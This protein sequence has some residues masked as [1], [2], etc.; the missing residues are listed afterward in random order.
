MRQSCHSTRARLYPVSHARRPSRTLQPSELKA[1]WVTTSMRM[2]AIT[3]APLSSTWKCSRPLASACTMVRRF[4]VL[5]LACAKQSR[6]DIKGKF[7]SETKFRENP[8][9]FVPHILKPNRAALEALITKPE[10]EKKLLQRL[11]KKADIYALN[12]NPDGEPLS[13]DS[14]RK[15]DVDGVVELYEDYIIPLTKEVEVRI[16][17]VTGCELDTHCA[18]QVDYLLARLQGMTQQQIDA[19]AQ[20]NL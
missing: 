2:T 3:A 1:W 7:V 5:D 18:F 12:F 6:D 20:N 17:I 4:L 9:A 19:L 14:P 11:R 10:V 16:F 15:I 13:A 8:A